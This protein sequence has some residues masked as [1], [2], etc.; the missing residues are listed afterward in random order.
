MVAH[1]QQLLRA[2]KVPTQCFRHFHYRLASNYISDMTRRTPSLILM[3]ISAAP[4]IL[5]SCTQLGRRSILLANI[6]ALS[7]CHTSISMLRLDSFK[8][9]IILLSCLFFY[10]I[11]WVFCSDVVSD[12]FNGNLCGRVQMM[13]CW[14]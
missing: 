1:E 5:F 11:G 2:P 13:K 8:T 14:P 10:D 3:F 12:R 7:F 9:G 6:L 4:S